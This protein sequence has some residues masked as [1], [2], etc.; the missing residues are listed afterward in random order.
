MIL[1]VLLKEKY[2]VQKE[3]SLKAKNDLTKYF[4]D[5]HSDIKDIEKEYKV[6]FNYSSPRRNVLK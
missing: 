4:S 6:K 1:N 3:F 2:K 5:T